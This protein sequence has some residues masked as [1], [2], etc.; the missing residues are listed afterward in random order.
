MPAK[1]QI[2][3]AERRHR[4][5]LR[6]S[7][8]R[9]AA[10]YQGRLEKARRKELRR[11]LELAKDY[12]VDALADVIRE[13]IDESGYLPGWWQ[14]LWTTIGTPY[15]QD[16]AKMLREEKAAQEADV[17]TAQLRQYA[18]TRAGNEITIVSGTWK[19]SLVD[20]V[21]RNL[22]AEP[23][24]GIEKLTRQIYQDYLAT[25]ERWQCR[26]IAQTEGMIGMAEAGD[27]ASRTLDVPFTKQWVISGLGNTRASHEL[28]DGVVVDQYEPFSLPGGMM[29]YPHDTSMGADAG[30]IIN[31]A[32]DCIRR[33][34]GYRHQ[35]PPQPRQAEPPAVPV[36]EVVPV[37]PVLTEDQRLAE[38]IKE[39]SDTLPAETKLAIAK[40]D[41]EL[42][43]A[44]GITKGKPMPLAK[45]D[46]QHANPNFALNDGY[47]KNCATCTPAFIL[48]SRGFDVTAKAK[49]AGSLN[50]SASRGGLFKMWRNADG[51]P[52]KPETVRDWMRAKGYERMNEKRYVQFFE[53][54]CKAQGDYAISVR[55]KG[56]DT[57][58]ATILRRGKDGKLVYIESQKYDKA[59][60]MTLSISEICADASAKPWSGNGV[61]RVDDK[62]FDTY[63]AGL[64]DVK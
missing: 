61:M 38:I 16:V 60:G 17:W 30:E 4:D 43:K 37:A 32:C 20:I 7:G 58:H 42:E 44:L 12:Q 1:K 49:T 62:L 24:I 47:K 48:R 35:A 34:Q 57:G 45:A 56:E 27:V 59:K 29:M 28:M 25:L 50:E 23:G 64:F 41:L 8:L 22:D 63:W 10:V 26:R 36:P 46:Q 53:E 19:D 2:T 33:P 51:T 40:N 54:K 11:V 9:V 52:A 6:R 13:N 55:W 5:D 31:C 18:T 21:R 3:K 15:A 39:M 14:G